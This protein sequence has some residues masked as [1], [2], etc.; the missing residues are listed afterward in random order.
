MTNDDDAITVDNAS[1]ICTFPSTGIMCSLC[2]KGY[3]IDYPGEPCKKC[4]DSTLQ[5]MLIALACILT[6]IFLVYYVKKTIRKAMKS[7]GALGSLWKILFSSLQLNA[8]ALSFSFSWNDSYDTT[9]Q[10]EN[11][12]SSMG[13]A[14]LDFDCLFSSSSFSENYT[15]LYIEV[16]LYASFPFLGK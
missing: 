8:I 12:V 10:A 6:F 1:M 9:M 5:L 3:S 14:M 13:L 11:A 16:A 7:K 15:S 4:M 2:E